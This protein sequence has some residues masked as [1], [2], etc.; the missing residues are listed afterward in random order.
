MAAN[1]SAEEDDKL[2]EVDDG[3]DDKGG[4]G[5]GKKKK[6]KKK[7]GG[8]GGPKQVEM[9]APPSEDS[10]ERYASTLEVLRSDADT[11]WAS[12]S[13]CGLA[14]KKMRKVAANL[15]RAP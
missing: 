9:L 5:A 13:R 2:Y 7:T 6:K 4:S 8:G 15:C 3:A 14:E 12:F 1:P 10:Q 11:M